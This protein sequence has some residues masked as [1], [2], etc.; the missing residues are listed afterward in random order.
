MTL[1][2]GTLPFLSTQ[3]LHLHC[4]DDAT[5][6]ASLLQPDAF[7]AHIRSAVPQDWP[8]RYWDA[9]AVEWVLARTASAPRDA[10]V[11][12]WLVMLA[13][14]GAAVGTA[15]FKGPPDHAG[16]VEVGYGV[17]QSHWRRGLATEAVGALLT[18]AW[19]DQRVQVVQAHTL[20]QDPAS[21]GVLR[22][23]GFAHTATVQDPDE[24]AVDRFQLPRAQK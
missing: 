4:M 20:A 10:F 11:R 23:H 8:P 5:L 17:V 19:N 1:H 2:P 21:G 3:R 18:W 22:K 13:S 14:T 15:G 7:A 9:A 12:P 16:M 6:R 24:G